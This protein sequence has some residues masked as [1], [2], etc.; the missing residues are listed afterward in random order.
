MEEKHPEGSYFLNFN[1]TW[2]PV[3]GDALEAQHQRK[4]KLNQVE[5]ERLRGKTA[6]PG[7]S[8]VQFGRKII[9]DEV[10]AYLANL[11]LAKRPHKTIQSKRGFL[12][13]FL[14]IIGKTYVDE[15][16]RDDV[17]KY[18]NKLMTEYVA[19][20]VDNQWLKTK[21]HMQKSD[22]LE[23]DQND[24]E[25]YSDGE[26]I[27]LEKHT[28]GKM[29]LLVRLF[30]STDCRDM[31]IAHLTSDDVNPRTKEILIRRKEC[32]DCKDCIFPRRGWQGYLEAKDE[33]RHPQYSRQ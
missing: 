6:P 12:T 25:P 17:L 20:S 9:K 23:Y 7:P 22:W 31:E 5:Y 2:I 29:N 28:T 21:L 19:K 27:A 26:V 32:N 1:N 33:G 14:Q 10:D 15:F 16:S 8:L 30:R 18:R 11:E 24:P 3:R 4:L 13:S